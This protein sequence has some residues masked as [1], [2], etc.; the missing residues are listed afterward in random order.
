MSRVSGTLDEGVPLGVVTEAQVGPA[1]SGSARL[2]QQVVDV[3]VVDLAERHP[4]GEPGVE[5]R[6]H[7]EAPVRR[8]AVGIGR[9]RTCG[10]ARYIVTFPDLLSGFRYGD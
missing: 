2:L 6:V 10:V 9:I 7:A 8:R 1:C 5:I 4:D 3:L